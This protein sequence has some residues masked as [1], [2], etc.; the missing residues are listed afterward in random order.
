MWS[1][2]KVIKFTQGFRTDYQKAIIDEKEKKRLPGTNM[3]DQQF[4]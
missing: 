2:H 3:Y 1:Q 4:C